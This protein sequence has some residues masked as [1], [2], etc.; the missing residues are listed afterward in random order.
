MENRRYQAQFNINH[1]PYV[2][3]HCLVNVSCCLPPA[4]EQLLC[5]TFSQISWWTQQH[6]A[7]TPLEKFICSFLGN[8][9]NIFAHQQIYI[10]VIAYDIY[11]KRR[12]VMLYI[13]I[14]I[15]IYIYI[16]IKW[17]V[18]V[19]V[20]VS[21]CLPP[22]AEQLLCATFSQISWW[23]QQHDATTPLE[24]F[25]CS[26]L[27]NDVNI[28][29]HQQIYIYVI[30]YDIYEKRRTVMLYIYI[31]ICIYI[32]IKWTVFV[33]VTTKSAQHA[34]DCYNCWKKSNTNSSHMYDHG[35]MDNTNR[36]AVK[37][38]LNPQ[39]SDVPLTSW[40][41]PFCNHLYIWLEFGLFSTI[42]YIY[43]SYIWY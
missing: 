30:A 7:T 9:V 18:F 42:I 14:C 4:A 12:T 25:I 16:Y 23:T 43:I 24:K 26:F 40:R 13:Y 5:A 36:Q 21:C 2:T 20:Y 37:Y 35:F 3:S 38:W 29:A 33:N 41:Q 11:E 17:T 28:F 1:Y 27:G 10:Y 15:C 19:N 32:Y 34:H 39:T 6:D 8:D 22:A 31:C